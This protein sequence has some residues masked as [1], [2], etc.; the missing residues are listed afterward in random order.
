[1]NS[2]LRSLLLFGLFAAPLAA[3]VRLPAI[4]GSHMVLQQKST[5]TLWGWANPAEAVTVSTS[6]S[7]NTAQATASNGGRWSVAIQTPQAGGP[8]SVRIR[9]ANEI[10]L[11]DVLIGEVWLCSGQSNMEWSGDL[12][13]RQSQEEA[14]GATNNLIRFFH[15]PKATADAP[16]DHVDAQW[17]VCN[18]ADMRRFSAIG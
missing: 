18:P 6:W 1:M 4:V 11:D 13:V 15:V 2:F 16:Q 10:V 17:V 12:G 5:V 7:T 8:H 3:A 14:P 9:A